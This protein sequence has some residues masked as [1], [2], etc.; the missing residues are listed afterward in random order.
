MICSLCL[1]PALWCSPGYR[2]AAFFPVKE[3]SSTFFL[4]LV[5]TL[6]WKCCLSPRCRRPVLLGKMIS[7]TLNIH[8]PSGPL[9]V[10]GMLRQPLMWFIFYVLS[11][12]LLAGDFINCFL[13]AYKEPCYYLF[14]FPLLMEV[15]AGGLLAFPSSK[16]HRSTL[17][18]FQNDS[19]GVYVTFFFFDRAAKFRIRVGFLA[20]SV[21]GFV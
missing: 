4:K 3:I 14:V 11:I 5:L 20:S 2:C 21:S 19:C 1:S 15:H 16:M 12:L 8:Q 13:I 18:C 9:S 6:P 17:S 7:L 10:P